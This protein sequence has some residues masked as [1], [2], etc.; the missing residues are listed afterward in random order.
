MDKMTVKVSAFL[1]Y[2]LLKKRHTPNAELLVYYDKVG[3]P[4]P[5]CNNNR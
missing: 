4:E 3:S 1:L 2:P 5:Q